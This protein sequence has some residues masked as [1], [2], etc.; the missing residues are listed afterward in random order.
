[1]RSLLCGHAAR[2]VSLVLMPVQILVLARSETAALAAASLA[3]RRLLLL[4][5]ASVHGELDR[6][7]PC[8]SAPITSPGR[9][10]WCFPRWRTSFS[11]P[12][13]TSRAGRYSGFSPAFRH[14]FRGTPSKAH[15]RSPRSM[16]SGGGSPMGKSSALPEGTTSDGNGCSH[17]RLAFGAAAFGAVPQSPTGV[18][19]VHRCDFLHRHPRHADGSLS[20]ADRRM[21]GRHSV[22]CRTFS[23]V[24]REGALEGRCRFWRGGGL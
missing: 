6:R 24:L 13:R 4:A 15:H 12:S 21:A 18:V 3:S 10:S 23:G 2:H 1:M 22:W 9:I 14:R 19:H 20:S 17:S 16:T 7:V 8:S 5:C 11:L